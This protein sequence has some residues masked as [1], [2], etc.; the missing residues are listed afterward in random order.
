[1]LVIFMTCLLVSLNI[2]H[3]IPAESISETDYLANFFYE[4][5]NQYTTEDFVQYLIDLG[6]DGQ[7]TMESSDRQVNLSLHEFMSSSSPEQNET[8]S[9]GDV[10]RRR[11]E[12]APFSVTQVSIQDK[13]ISA[14]QRLFVVVIGGLVSKVLGLEP[15]VLEIILALIPLP[16]PTD[17]VEKCV[18]KNH[19]FDYF[20]LHEVYTPNG[21]Y[22]YV[23]TSKRGINVS[24]ELVIPGYPPGDPRYYGDPDVELFV[25]IY[26]SEQWGYHGA[27][28][29]YARDRYFAGLNC[30]YFDFWGSGHLH[31]KNHYLLPSN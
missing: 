17:T 8:Y 14:L 19:Y 20:D 18:I 6:Y 23:H 28:L 7:I 26:L 2:S 16:S 30:I 3:A 9:Y 4:N 12:A 10:R 11:L 15:F 1:M 29:E 21:W 5:G 25:E 24:S 27:N 31:V 13:A 22:P